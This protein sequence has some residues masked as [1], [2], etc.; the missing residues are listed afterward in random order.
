MVDGQT[1]K[2]LFMEERWVMKWALKVLYGAY[3]GGALRGFADLR[4]TEWEWWAIMVPTVIL[5]AIFCE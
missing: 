4:W 1:N 5:V 2:I 3:I